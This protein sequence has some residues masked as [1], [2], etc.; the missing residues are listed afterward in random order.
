M[1]GVPRFF[2]IFLGSLP[3]FLLAFLKSFWSPSCSS[4]RC[5]LSPGLRRA[6]ARVLANFCRL[7]VRCLQ[8]RFWDRTLFF[9]GGAM[10]TGSI[11]G[12]DT[13]PSAQRH[14]GQCALIRFRQRLL[15]LQGVI[16]GVRGDVGD[17]LHR[18]GDFLQIDLSLSMTPSG[19]P[20]SELTG[21]LRVPLRTPLTP[22]AETARSGAS[23]SSMLRF[24]SLRA[25]LPA[26]A[27]PGPF[28][29]QQLPALAVGLQIDRGDDAVADQ[30]RQ[31]EIAELPL[32]LRHIG[33]ELVVV[34][35]E[36]FRCACA[37]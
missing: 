33:L 7:P 35:E 17:V 30:H 16:G 3:D 20:L 27:D 14:I 11:I 21:G 32:L 26:V 34:A 1:I 29:H 37:G 36:Q 24:S 8:H 22:P 5:L 10:A 13:R 31:G 4:G 18:V 25:A 28:L 6:L 12:L 15:R 2:L 9:R 23:S 19:M